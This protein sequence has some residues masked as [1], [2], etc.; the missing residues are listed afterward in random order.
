MD[1]PRS[2]QLD[3][4]SLNILLV[5]QTEGHIE[6]RTAIFTGDVSICFLIEETADTIEGL[7]KA[8]TSS[9]DSFSFPDRIPNSIS[10]SVAEPNGTKQTSVL[11][12]NVFL[13]VV[14]RYER[15]IQIVILAIYLTF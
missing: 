4:Y 7:N 3:K 9:P 12:L 8:A 6:R 13:S 15:P 1:S 11:L 2:P 10:L 5:K 14:G